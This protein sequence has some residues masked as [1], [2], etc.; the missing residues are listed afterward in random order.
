MP[1]VSITNQ[2][3]ITTRQLFGFNKITYSF[4]LI[5]QLIETEKILIVFLV[6]Q[7]S[8]FCVN[9]NPENPL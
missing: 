1:D 4:Y 3:Q 6:S 8:K 2:Y 7:Q 5:W 9:N